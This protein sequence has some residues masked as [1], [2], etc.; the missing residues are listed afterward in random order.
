MTTQTG[1]TISW[2]ALCDS[3]DKGMR[4]PVDDYAF[5]SGRMMRSKG[6]AS[7]PTVIEPDPGPAPPAGQSGPITTGI[8]VV[9]V[10][11]P[12]GVI[13]RTA[14]LRLTSAGT[15]ENTAQIVIRGVREVDTPSFDEGNPKVTERPET[16]TFANWQPVP[17]TTEG[18]QYDSVELADIVQEIIGL[19]GWQSGNPLAFRFVGVGYREFMSDHAE[20]PGQWPELI[21]EYG[22]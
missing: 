5:S 2:A 6:G 19:P 9:S 13:I 21:F 17:W 4:E 10:A 7:S 11:I 14:E 8:R 20:D 18:L 3:V 16:L 22:S 12:A 15:Y 1:R